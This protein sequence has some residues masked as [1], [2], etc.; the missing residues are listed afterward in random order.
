MQP[1]PDWWDWE[2]ELSPH[3]L[4][5]MKE[6]GF[7][8]NDL[9]EMLEAAKSHRPGRSPGRHIIVTRHNKCPWEVVVEP[10]DE[11]ELLVVITAYA[12]T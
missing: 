10:D 1:W 7:N 5:R 9:R 2:L 6:R 4:K 11:D 12:V 8:E 3:L